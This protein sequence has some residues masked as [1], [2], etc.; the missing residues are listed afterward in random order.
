MNNFDH[1]TLEIVKR[2]NE[3]LTENLSK[4]ENLHSRFVDVRH[5][6]RI[7]REFD[8]FTS[9]MN[10]SVHGN[11]C[12]QVV[13]RIQLESEI[14][15]RCQT[16]NDFLESEVSEM[17]AVLEVVMNNYRNTMEKMMRTDASSMA[18]E[19]TLEDLLAERIEVQS[20]YIEQMN[21]ALSC[22]G[23]TAAQLEA[24]LKNEINELKIRNLSLESHLRSA[25]DILKH[26]R[27]LLR[28]SS[29]AGVQ[30]DHETNNDIECPNSGEEIA[31]NDAIYS[32]TLENSKKTQ[33]ELTEYVFSDSNP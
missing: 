27:H 14:I 20:K 21:T 31:L 18:N 1:E 4:V 3:Q 32:Q 10:S 16:E 24:K 23:E 15:R 29:D 22:I 30:C 13:N 7:M 19:F 28:E 6:M 11:N 8:E 12:D 5:K 26:K 25:C 17:R 2:M 33:T 9:N